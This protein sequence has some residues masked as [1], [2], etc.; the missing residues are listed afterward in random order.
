MS[1]KKIKHW[2]STVL[3]SFEKNKQVRENAIGVSKKTGKK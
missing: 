1:T 2:W 3:K